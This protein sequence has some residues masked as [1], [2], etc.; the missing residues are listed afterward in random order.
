MTE[1][2]KKPLTPVETRV[3]DAVCTYID[4]QDRPPTARELMTLLEYK[5]VGHMMRLLQQ[6]Q[7]KG[8]LFRLDD[9]SSRTWWPVAYPDGRRFPSRRELIQEIE[10][11]RLR[12]AGNNP[13]R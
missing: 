3:L 10:L 7:E 12:H 11:L 13:N 5:S 4:E 2:G 1:N 9:T 8:G 6:L